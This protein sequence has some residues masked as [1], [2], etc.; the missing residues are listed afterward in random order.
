MTEPSKSKAERETLRQ[1]ITQA[2]DEAIETARQNWWRVGKD[3]ID[4]PE[5]I[6]EV[7]KLHSQAERKLKQLQDADDQEDYRENNPWPY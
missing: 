7:Y 1:M 6:A 3:P 4:S 5:A 2:R